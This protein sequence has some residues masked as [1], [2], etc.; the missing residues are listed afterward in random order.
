MTEKKFDPKKLHKL[1]N[2][3]RLL[4]IPPE[5][6]WDKINIEEPRVLVDIGAGTGFFCVNFLKYI[7]KGKIFACDISDIMI[8]WMNDNI[9]PRYPDIVPLKM[10]ENTVP[11]ED[12]LADLVYMMNLHHELD[13]PEKIL[14]ESFRILKA[15][16]K[17]LIVD[18]KK[19]DMS[20]GPPTH[21]R[22]SP[23]QVKDELLN[24]KFTNVDIF[25]KM[26]KHFM[27]VAE[28]K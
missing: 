10:E 28:K 12:E 13:N 24:L 7:K 14:K 11:L 2:P 20:E 3:D 6:I 16:G 4:D 21:I 19:E 25:T 18:W 1:N 15:N 22:Y 9:C 26:P 27:V 23:E 17:I 5:Y 8:Q